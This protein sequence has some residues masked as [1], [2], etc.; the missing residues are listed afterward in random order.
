MP[1]RAFIFDL[2]GV[3][4]DT[5]EYHYQA[6]RQLAE[7]EGIPFD[8][9]RNEAL[10]GVSRRES[11]NLLLDGRTI[12]EEQALRW[13]ERKNSYYLDKIRQM[14]PDEVLSGARQLL[15]DIRA[16][17][18]M[19]AIASA[20]KN[21]GEVARRL[22]LLGAVDVLADGH[23]VR[24]T[25]PAPD[26]FLYTAEKLGVP[27]ETCVVVEDAAAGIEAAQRAGMLTIGIGPKER[28]G[29][30]GLVLPNLE[31]VQ[32]E[33]LLRKLGGGK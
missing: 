18:L 14:A 16:A 29:K 1:I 26:L 7:E 13:M 12:S 15:A 9:E 11:L 25:K 21:A 28:V 19:V 17:G 8:R 2:D 30:A 31:G 10:R 22:G 4:T 24:R 33:D 23:S 3:L 5:A 27:A 32:V 6:W 20:S